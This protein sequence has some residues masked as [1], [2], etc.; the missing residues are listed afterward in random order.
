MKKINKSAK[1]FAL[2]FTACLNTLKNRIFLKI[3]PFSPKPDLNDQCRL[4]LGQL[5]E[6]INVIIRL[7]DFLFYLITAL[8]LC[9]LDKHKT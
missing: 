9:T 7:S 8:S 2:T 1:N 4:L 6:V 5:Q 3:C